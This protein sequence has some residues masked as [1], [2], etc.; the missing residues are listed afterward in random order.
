MGSQLVFLSPSVYQ[1]RNAHNLLQDFQG[2]IDLYTKSH[3]LVELLNTFKAQS[4]N[5]C[6]LMLEMY[7]HLTEAKFFDRQELEL[8]QTWIQAIIK[9]I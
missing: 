1:I 9:Y 5:P 2:E 8:C 7:T 6:D 4:S 3:E